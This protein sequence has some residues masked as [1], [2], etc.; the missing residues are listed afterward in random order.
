VTYTPTVDDSGE[1]D[2][3][4]GVVIDVTARKQAEDELRHSRERIQSDLDALTRLHSVSNLCGNAESPFDDC[5][6]T[7][8]DAAIAF[9]RADRGNIQVLERDDASLRLI[10][11][12]GFEEPFLRHFA[13]VG[14]DDAAACGEAMRKGERVVIE[15]VAHSALFAGQP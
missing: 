1:V 2:G 10:A 6:H 5:V 8:L 13:S 14:H 7:I 3:W 15:D 12:R 9:T 11:H 4:V